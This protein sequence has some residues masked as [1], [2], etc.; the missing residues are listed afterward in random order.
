MWS[1]N[2][3]ASTRRATESAERVTEAER[4]VRVVLV[5]SEAPA[6]AAKSWF[7][8]SYRAAACIA[9]ASRLRGTHQAYWRPI[10]VRVAPFQIE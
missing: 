7:P 8:T 9:S 5:R 4:T 10:A 3:F 2:A 6:N 1:R